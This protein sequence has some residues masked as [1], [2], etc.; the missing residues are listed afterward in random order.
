MH[1]S[2]GPFLLWG[3]LKKEDWPEELLFG[4]RMDL[5]LMVSF[6]CCLLYIAFTVLVLS[7]LIG[8]GWLIGGLIQTFDLEDLC[9]W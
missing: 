7:H 9:P 5:A 8:L 2:Y 4:P 3:N 1:V 6:I